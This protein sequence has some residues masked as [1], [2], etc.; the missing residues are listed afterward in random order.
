MREKIYLHFS[1]LSVF[2][3]SA[4]EPV[5]VLNWKLYLHR[6]IIATYIHPGGKEAICSKQQQP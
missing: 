2:F 5:T 3:W 1:Y 6:V 4:L